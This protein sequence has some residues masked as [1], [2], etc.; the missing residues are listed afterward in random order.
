MKSWIPNWGFF[1]STKYFH[2]DSLCRDSNFLLTSYMYLILTNSL[3]SSH[4][5]PKQNVKKIWQVFS[6]L[7][8]QQQEQRI[9][10]LKSIC[11]FFIALKSSKTFETFKTSIHFVLWSIFEICPV[12][13]CV[14]YTDHGSTT[15]KDYKELALL[16]S[17]FCH[18]STLAFF[19]LCRLSH[20]LT[21]G[22]RFCINGKKIAELT[23]RLSLKNM[24]PILG[25]WAQPLLQRFVHWLNK[26]YV[27]LTERIDVRC[28]NKTH[29][30]FL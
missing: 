18:I 12:L 11:F 29:G 3:I 6:P 21:L 24:G 5:N 17:R 1:F 4:T 10:W 16:F 8:Q 15:V 20:T 9:S 28:L 13:N 7:Q 14:W 30:G 22:W 27:I 2:E 25:D 19:F 26:F 23:S